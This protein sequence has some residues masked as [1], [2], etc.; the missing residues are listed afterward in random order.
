MGPF[1]SS[2]AVQLWPPEAYT[3]HQCVARPFL[4]RQFRTHQL[5]LELSPTRASYCS[6]HIS[7]DTL[8]SC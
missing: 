6:V 7:N 4:R 8:A 2:Q 3:T 1:L 5:S